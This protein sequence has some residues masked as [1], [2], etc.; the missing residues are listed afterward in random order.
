M[1]LDQ[2]AIDPEELRR[3][4]QVIIEEARRMKAEQSPV[5]GVSGRGGEIR[6]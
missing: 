2:A 6:F 5:L 3:E 1:R 4:L